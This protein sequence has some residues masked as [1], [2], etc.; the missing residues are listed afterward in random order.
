MERHRES[1][2][3]RIVYTSAAKMDYYE[4]NMVNSRLKV[5]RGYK[6]S[7]RG[8]VGLEREESDPLEFLNNMIMENYIRQVLAGE[9]FEECEN[10]NTYFSE[11]NLIN[12]ID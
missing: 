8:C 4:G 1:D 9:K 11:Y 2:C 10:Y 7:E 6:R 5:E 3:P 12:L